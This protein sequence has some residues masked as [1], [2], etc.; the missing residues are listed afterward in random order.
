LAD[1]VLLPEKPHQSRHDREQQ[2][3]NELEQ[4]G[5]EDMHGERV[6]AGSNRPPELNTMHAG[7]E[8][9]DGSQ[10]RSHYAIAS[11]LPDL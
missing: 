10:R 1:A 5:L 11:C 9:P 7:M 3:R 8:A 6:G 2:S 4:N